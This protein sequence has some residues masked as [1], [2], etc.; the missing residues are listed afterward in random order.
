MVT[1]LAVPLSPTN[2]T[3]LPLATKQSKSHVLRTVSTVGTNMDANLAP[4]SSSSGV[5]EERQVNHF[6]FST[7]KRYS[8]RLALGSVVGDRPSPSL[9]E[10]PANFLMKASTRSRSLKPCF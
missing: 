7:S 8:Y 5:T 2:R 1:V 10:N 9:Q 6:F 3:G 4:W